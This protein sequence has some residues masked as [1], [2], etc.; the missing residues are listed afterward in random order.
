[1]AEASR[2]YQL[3]IINYPLFKP[4][5][6]CSKIGKPAQGNIREKAQ[7]AQRGS[8]NQKAVESAGEC[9]A[10]E[11]G[12]QALN[13]SFAEHSSADSCST[14][15]ATKKPLSESLSEEWGKEHILPLFP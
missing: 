3:S 15:A 7:K 9:S 11:W 2:H 4:S 10:E 1:V 12:D 13:Y 14:L 5:L 8:R 6:G